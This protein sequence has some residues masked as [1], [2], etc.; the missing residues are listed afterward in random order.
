MHQLWILSTW[1]ELLFNKTIPSSLIFILKAV[2]PQS[3]AVPNFPINE[4]IQEQ[5]TND[6]LSTSIQ[7]STNQFLELVANE[8]TE[9]S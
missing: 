7:D 5:T 1:V 3:V 8:N 4:E 6:Y 2:I 9:K